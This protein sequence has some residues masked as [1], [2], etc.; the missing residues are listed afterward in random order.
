[1]LRRLKIGGRVNMLIAVPL[2]ALIAFAALGYI[3]LQRAS[4]RGD[5]YKA[6]KQASDLRASVAPPAASL[7]EAWANVSYIGVLAASPDGFTEDGLAEVRSH[8]ATIDN[9]QANFEAAGA[10]WSQQ[11]LDDR[12][13]IRLIE[14]GGDAGRKFFQQVNDELKPA[15]DSGDAQKVLAV[16]RSMEW[17]Y[18]LQQT[19]VDRAME[20]AGPEITAREQSTDTYVGDVILFAGAA[21]L[22]L[23]VLTLL[24]SILVR[25]SIVRPIRRLAEQ[26]KSVATKDLPEV[27]Q[28]VQDLPADAA[29]PHLAT[30]EVGTRDELAELGASFNSVQD[31]AVDLAAEQAMARRI[32]SENLVNIARRNQNLLGRTLGFISTLEQ[33]ER[34][35]EALDNLFR[36]DH[37]TTRMR[38]NAQSLLVLAGA[39]PTRLWSPVVAIGDVV[40]AALSEVENYGQVELA[41]LGDIGVQGSVASEVAHLL[42]EL[43]ENATSFSPPTSAVT[44]VGRAV[45]D[46]HQLAIFDYGLGMTADELADAN[47]RLNQVSSFDRESNKMLGFQVV[48]RLAARHDIKVMLTTTPGGSGVT[49]IVRL[50]KSI[51]EVVAAPGNAG[52]PV[53]DV[54]AMSERLS[55]PLTVPASPAAPT[56]D[57]KPTQMSDEAL[58]AAMKSPEA[59]PAQMAPMTPAP[60]TIPAQAAPVASAAPTLEPLTTQSGLTK[61]VRGAQMPELGS[62]PMDAPAPRPADEVRS[63]L[64]SLQRGVDLGRQRQGDS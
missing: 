42:A 31:A 33:G 17:R 29:V 34:D 40:R 25:R 64:A 21:T 10:Y 5:E 51:L 53:V 8:L 46:G 48:A 45:P 24:L 32:V 60:L 14:M 22:G 18:D 27:V 47:R 23:L 9:A 20:F 37:L 4:V 59:A 26:A 35:P 62:T 49:A 1:M 54:P 15:I 57:Q 2:L 11:Q 52:S 3:A 55:S 30:F 13:N 16:I 44:V 28:T 19:G 56:F 58:W 63:T 6:L 39:E 7:L 36:L 38:R 41:D 12:V 61:R 43:L 50:P